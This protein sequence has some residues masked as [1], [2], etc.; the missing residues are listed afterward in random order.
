MADNGTG[1]VGIDTGG[2]YRPVPV[3]RRGDRR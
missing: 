1:I 2:L 3:F